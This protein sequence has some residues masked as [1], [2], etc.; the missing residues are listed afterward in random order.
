MIAYRE[1]VLTRFAPAAD[2]QVFAIVFTVRHRVVRHVWHHQRVITD[3]ALQLIQCG[4]GSIQLVTQ[5]VHFAT[6]WLDIFTARFGRADGFRSGV[7]FCLQC[8]SFYLQNLT[9][10]FL[11]TQQIQIEFKASASQFYGDCV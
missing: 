2:F 8:F 3:L 9:A 5:F 11:R 4:L 10:L 1:I 6:Q 7:T